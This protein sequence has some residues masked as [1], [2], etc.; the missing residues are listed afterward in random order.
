MRALLDQYTAPP[1]NTK[2]SAPDR[3][4]SGAFP[5]VVAGFPGAV[6]SEWGMG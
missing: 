3:C 6:A 4:K 1:R 5:R 2:K